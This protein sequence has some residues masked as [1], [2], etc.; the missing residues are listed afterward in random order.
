M[1]TRGVVLGDRYLLGERIATG[2][3]GAVW[4]CTDT[5]LGREVA[6][7]VLLPSLVADPEFTAR[8]HAEARMLA[9]LRHPG[10]VAV[11]DFG[12]ATLADGSRVSYLVM[13]YVDGEPLT[14]WVRRAGRLDPASTMSV[15]AQAARALHAAHAAGIVHRDV[16]PGNLL[17]KRDGS[18][19]LVDFGIAR[20]T[21][22][23][24]L[25]AAHMVLGTASYMS[26]EQADGRPVSP[27]TDVYA[28]G[29]VAY[30]CLAGRP[31]F[32]GDNPLAVAMRHAQDE[33]PPLPGDTPPAVVEVVRRALAKRPADRHS[34]AAALADAAQDA[35][36]ATLAVLPVPPRP[37][38]A[39]PGRA[40]A[41]HPAAPG[42][43]PGRPV[44]HPV[45]PAQ[46]PPPTTGPTVEQHRPDRARRLALA[47][48]A[49]V[50][51]IALVAL[52][53]VLRP[54][55]PDDPADRA[56]AL[57]GG[58]L[59]A[60]PTRPGGEPT[61]ARPTSNRA[62]RPG[63]S[64]SARPG[65]PATGA[66]TTPGA[67]ARSTGATP[68]TAAPTAA[69][70]TSAPAT[71]PTTGPAS[72][73]AGTGDRPNP[74]TAEQ[75][76]GAGYQVIDSADLVAAGARQGTVYLLYAAGSGTNCTVTLKSSDVGTATAAA[77]WLEVRGGS[78]STD[79]GAFAY[80]AGPVRADAAG[81]CVRWGGS[82]GDV[83]YD[84]P[85]E[86]CG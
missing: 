57:T 58:S 79:R 45:R 55:G 65:R 32:E 53:A 12:S 82:I 37:P 75:A 33:P 84:S 72:P 76:C 78:R 7:K 83:G 66:P 19:V 47:G 52:V 20:S 28:L 74:Y 49:G 1:L 18:V 59:T 8:F 5:L 24:G 68:T 35:R 86:H 50:A 64:A 51:L 25:T 80:Y 11:H 46:V 85:F 10:I 4:R 77:A 36:D 29:A 43:P 3:M 15:V 40:T 44:G 71:G 48:A 27:V 2:G 9:A 41:D 54:D 56:A 21:A 61:K 62:G 81:E 42:V 16:K 31:P 17:V 34:S 73:S 60:A 26:P 22:M 39:V 70:A 14:T 30:Y 38:W 6:V 63:A 69:P 23:A 67:P 13:E